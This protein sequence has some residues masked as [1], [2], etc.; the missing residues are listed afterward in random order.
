MKRFQKDRSKSLAPEGEEAAIE[1][2]VVSA[3]N[4]DAPARLQDGHR[5]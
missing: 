1:Y 5:E 3:S 4:Y 2:S